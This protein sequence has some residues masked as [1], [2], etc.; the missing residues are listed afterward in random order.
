MGVEWH[1]MLPVQ[2]LKG[3]WQRPRPAQPPQAAR[4]RRRR[5]LRRFAEHDRP[6]YDMRGNSARLQWVDELCEVHARWC[7]R[8]TRS[9]SPTGSARPTS[10]SPARAAGLR[11]AAAG[12]THLAQ[13]APSG[14]AYDQETTSRCS[15]ACSTTRSA[16]SASRARTSA[17]RVPARR[18][19]DHTARRRVD[20]E[21]F[22]GEIG[23]QFMVF[24]RPALVLLRAAVGRG[25]DLPLPGAAHP[26]LQARLGRRP[27]R[28][29]RLLEHGHPLLPARPRG[30]ADG[31][32]R[33]SSTRSRPSRTSTDRLSRPLQLV[34]WEKRGF[35]RSVVDNVMRLTSAVQ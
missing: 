6:S 10:C 16:A 17:G 3:R 12:G 24:P 32:R 7:T 25:E 5:G 35:W 18:D 31:L 4:G 27:G 30:H 34:D 14:P 21:L 1:L 9:S 23:D 33:T 22:V 28:G 20:V 19:H 26:P 29:D 2:P 8:S 11:R 13:V 15:T